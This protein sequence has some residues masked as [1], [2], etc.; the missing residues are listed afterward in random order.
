MTGQVLCELRYIHRQ[1]S[2]ISQDNFDDCLAV[3]AKFAC[4]PV[5]LGGHGWICCCGHTGGLDSTS[6]LSYELGAITRNFCC[7]Q[8]GQA[9]RITLPRC[10]NLDSGNEV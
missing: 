1:L 9:G 10:V 6:L 8:S 7:I 2:L 5:I 4:I 3:I